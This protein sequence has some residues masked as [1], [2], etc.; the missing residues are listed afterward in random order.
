[1]TRKSYAELNTSGT[2]L[3]TS[4]NVYTASI[5]V[6]TE[7]SVV[8]TVSR[9]VSEKLPINAKFLEPSGITNGLSPSCLGIK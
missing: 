1:M 4:S 9:G 2:P 7:Y 5:A 3:S 8:K 6:R